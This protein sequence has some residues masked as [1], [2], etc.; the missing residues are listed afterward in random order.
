MALSEHEQRLLDEMER[1]L[2]QNDA[3]VVSTT[4]STGPVVSARSVTIVVLAVAIGLAIV[5]AGMA[6][7]QPLVGLAGFVVLIAGVA[8]ALLR[9]GGRP[10]AE[11]TEPPSP[12]P[13]AGR[14]A[15]AATKPVAQGDGKSFIDR[16]EDRWERRRDGEL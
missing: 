12:R 7:G 14:P 5:V 10:D 2:Y 16:M 9:G 13:A 1:S 4:P 11:S 3:D 15:G 8:W 6:L